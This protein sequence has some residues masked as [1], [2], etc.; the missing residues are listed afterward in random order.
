MLCLNQ[1]SDAETDQA[2]PGFSLL[3]E[4]LRDDQW[5][6]TQRLRRWLTHHTHSGHLV[7]VFFLSKSLY[8]I[9]K[10][11][12]DWD[13][14]IFIQILPFLSNNCLACAYL[15]LHSFLKHSCLVFQNP[16][17]DHCSLSVPDQN[18]VL[19]TSYLLQLWLS[20]LSTWAYILN[21]HI[22]ISNLCE[23][24]YHQS[25]SIYNAYLSTFPMFKI[26]HG[27]VRII[28]ETTYTS[29]QW[30]FATMVYIL[31]MVQYHFNDILCI[32]ISSIGID[33]I[34][35]LFIMLPFYLVFVCFLQTRC[36]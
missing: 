6:E 8:Q 2:S 35:L 24:W 9:I 36:W 4:L 10:M 16:S 17:C 23:C 3:M 27:K 21:T 15:I 14:K 13:T 32:K 33:N 19:A 30:L 5:H 18:F 1:Q 22:L 11:E 20:L 26:F 29:R 7:L 25:K 12:K 34:L 31:F 28:T